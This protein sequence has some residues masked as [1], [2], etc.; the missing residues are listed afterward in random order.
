[1]SH[2]RLWIKTGKEH[3]V[4]KSAE[5]LR[6]FVF[7]GSGRFRSEQ[8]K[9]W[10]QRHHTAPRIPRK[11]EAPYY[12]AVTMRTSAADSVVVEPPLASDVR[13][14]LFLLP[15]VHSRPA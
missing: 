2:Y 12:C 7:K 13:H 15:A 1:M 5:S 6:L 10:S 8:A 3:P 11:G 9:T 4:G 14:P